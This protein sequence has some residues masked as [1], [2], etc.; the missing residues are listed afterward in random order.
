MQKIILKKYKILHV[1]IIHFFINIYFIIF[2]IICSLNGINGNKHIM[3]NLIKYKIDIH[4]N[5][6]TIIQKY[7]AY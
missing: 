1:Y 3:R 6:K 7:Y 5:Q 4:D 2:L